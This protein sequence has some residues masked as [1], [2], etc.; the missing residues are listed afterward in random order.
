MSC[1][2]FVSP[3][4]ASTNPTTSTIPENRALALPIVGRIC[5]VGLSVT[6]FA[7]IDIR[8][9]YTQYSAQEQSRIGPKD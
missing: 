9:R 1:S 4:A 5:T 2:A 7:A 8:P 3:A 6:S